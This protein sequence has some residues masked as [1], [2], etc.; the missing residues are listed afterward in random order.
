MQ[1][2]LR[3]FK[4]VFFGG[5][6][7]TEVLSGAPGPA[8]DLPALDVQLSHIDATVLASQS[9]PQGGIAAVSGLVQGGWRVGDLA[10]SLSSVC[11]AAPHSWSVGAPFHPTPPHSAVRAFLP[12]PPSGFDINWDNEQHWAY[13]KSISC[14][15]LTPTGQRNGEPIADCFGVLGYPR[16]AILALADGANWGES[17]LRAA[18]CAVLAS[19]QHLHK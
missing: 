10:S 19:I 11:S 4:S 17:P 13:G 9:G 16:G 15:D 3:L 5:K 14:Y 7:K 12:L 2:L 6:T 1:G 18:R 8:G